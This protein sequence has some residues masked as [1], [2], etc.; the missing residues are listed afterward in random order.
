MSQP[1]APLL[2]ARHFTL[3]RRGVA[4]LD[5]VSIELPAG[6]TLALVGESG[7]GKSTFAVAAMGLLRPPEGSKA[8]P[9]AAPTSWRASER[10]LQALRGWRMG[11]CSRTPPALNPRHG[12]AA[13]GRRAQQRACAAAPRRSISS[14]WARRP[15]SPPGGHPHELSACSSASHRHRR[16]RARTADRG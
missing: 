10:E 7:A 12:A 13:P 16:L 11:R 1:T 9:Q 2:S 3:H 5:D 14:R 8:S 4:V 15:A 6:R